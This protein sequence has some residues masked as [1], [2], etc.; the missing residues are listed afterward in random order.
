MRVNQ[1]NLEKLQLYLRGQAPV[2]NC[3]WL[4]GWFSRETW[5]GRTSLH[6]YQTVRWSE[7][8]PTPHLNTIQQYNP[9]NDKRE[10][11][12]LSGSPLFSPVSPASQLSPATTMETDTLE[13]KIIFP[14]KKLPFHYAWTQLLTGFN[15]IIS[16]LKSVVNIW[17]YDGMI[18]IAG[19][20]VCSK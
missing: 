14:G 12:H 7:S 8:A 17:V 6:F 19:G 13:R 2:Q 4:A 15:R 1:S 20:V 10:Q 3:W 5:A 16:L 9:T 11:L 18:I